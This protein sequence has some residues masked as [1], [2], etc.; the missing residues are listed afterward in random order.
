M[1]FP[2]VVT[3]TVTNVKSTYLYTVTW[4][5]VIETLTTMQKNGTK[6]R[7][8][9]LTASATFL[10]ATT[11]MGVAQLLSVAC[12]R[13]VNYM[14]ELYDADKR[15]D[16]DSTGRTFSSDPSGTIAYLG[17]LAELV[18]I[19]QK[20]AG[21]YRFKTKSV[22]R[23][24]ERAKE[25]VREFRKCTQM[26]DSVYNTP[27]GKPHAELAGLNVARKAF[28]SAESLH[29]LDCSVQSFQGV[30]SQVMRVCPTL[31]K[32]GIRWITTGE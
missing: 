12:P 9:P 23:R 6:V 11:K 3:D 27:E 28:V 25:I 16:K 4:Q 29:A 7:P 13:T 31:L 30:L 17:R 24:L 1:R 2:V 26:I 18:Y 8:C 19:C 14:Q 10:S 5:H 21:I 20:S 22:D 32:S 15:M